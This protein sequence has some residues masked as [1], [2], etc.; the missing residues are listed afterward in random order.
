[1]SSRLAP[2]HHSNVAFWP[3]QGRLSSSTHVEDLKAVADL[4]K[5]VTE[6]QRNLKDAK[7]RL[8][9]ATKRCLVSA[10]QNKIDLESMRAL[11]PKLC[12]WEPRGRLPEDLSIKIFREAGV[13]ARFQAVQVC[14]VFSDVI[15]S[16][17]VR[18]A[19]DVKGGSIAV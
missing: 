2:A 11:K 15:R 13:D 7:L 18:G 14:N 5:T 6:L 16:G 12:F 1:M 9:E 10:R 17:R 3:L 4:T 8:K 19:F